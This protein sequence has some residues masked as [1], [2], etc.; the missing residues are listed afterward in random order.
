MEL[1]TQRRKMKE[2]RANTEDE[3]K[4]ASLRPGGPRYTIRSV[5]RCQNAE[6][7]LILHRDRNAACNIATNFRRLYRGEEPLRQH[8]VLTALEEQINNL[9]CQMCDSY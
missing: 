7:G 5:R 4:R 1:E 6:C 8:Y 3:K 9:E 2:E